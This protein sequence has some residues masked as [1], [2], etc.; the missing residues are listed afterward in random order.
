M[1]LEWRI[2]P[3]AASNPV[4]REL[5]SLLRKTKPP[6]TLGA[7]LINWVCFFCFSFWMYLLPVCFE[8]LLC[9]L[10]FLYCCPFSYFVFSFFSLEA[11]SRPAA[12]TPL[13]LPGQTVVL[14]LQPMLRPLNISMFQVGADTVFVWV[15]C[16][17]VECSPVT[18]LVSFLT[19]SSSDA[20]SGQ[21]LN[22]TIWPRG[23]LRSLGCEMPRIVLEGLSFLKFFERRREAESEGRRVE[24]L[25]FVSTKILML[26]V[27]ECPSKIPLC[28]LLLL[29]SYP[30]NKNKPQHHSRVLLLFPAC[31]QCGDSFY[32]LFREVY[33]W[34]DWLVLLQWITDWQPS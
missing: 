5:K 26:L 20:H 33:N 25:C 21:T 8:F 4:P 15:S 30:N 24:L 18:C 34:I 12:G 28:G 1:P 9:L 13:S 23:P 32:G 7:K 3:L 29:T 2:L 6:V 11:M 22:C 17:G 27:Y 14:S 31:L 16:H 10:C 19:L